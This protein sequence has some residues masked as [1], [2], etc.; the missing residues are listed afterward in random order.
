MT[1]TAGYTTTLVERERMFKLGT[2]QEPAYISR[3]F[4]NWKDATVTFNKQLKSNCHREAIEINELPKKTGDVG[5]LRVEP[6]R[7]SI[8]QRNV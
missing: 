8:K 7:E 1:N 6:K 3:G 5:E 4:T 2:K